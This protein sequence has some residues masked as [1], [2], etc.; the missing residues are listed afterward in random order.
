[1]DAA[2]DAAATAAA[3]NTL[4][5]YDKGGSYSM[6]NADDSENG[7]L[8]ANVVRPYPMRVAG[9]P[10]GWQYADATGVFTFT[11]RPDAR[12][13]AP[14][15]ISLPPRLYPNGYDVACGG[16]TATPA[17]GAVELTDLPASDSLTI[18]VSPR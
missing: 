3:G 4:W 5:S 18:T 8:L 7:A 16:C 15:V 11:L 12:V 9:D 6:L 13:T 17:A 1:M 10:V 2:Y 14:T